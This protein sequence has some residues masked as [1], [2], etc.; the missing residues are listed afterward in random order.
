MHAGL[1]SRNRRNEDLVPFHEMNVHVNTQECS[2]EENRNNEF[3]K[4]LHKRIVHLQEKNKEYQGIKEVRKDLDKKRT[5]IEGKYA[6]LKGI[7]W[8]KT[9]REQKQ[10]ENRNRLRHKNWL[11][12][13]CK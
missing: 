3:L 13:R 7:K 1:N 8:A 9:K 11:N 5:E 6:M 12:R 10:E 2:I 4:V